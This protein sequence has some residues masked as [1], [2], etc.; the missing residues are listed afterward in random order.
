[1]PIRLRP[2]LFCL[3]ILVSVRH[4]WAQQS[5]QI[6]LPDVQITA[7]K[8]VR[9][10]ADTY[11]LGDWRCTFRVSLDGTF[12]QIDGDI[13]FSE[14]AN[15]FTTITGTFSRRIEVGELAKCRLC[16]VSLAET[17]GVAAGPNIG[18]RG[19]R[20]YKGEG[21][22]RRARIVTD[23]FGEDVGHIGGT[24][25]FAPVRVVVRCDYAWRDE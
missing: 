13:I 21:I 14:K 5:F 23:T 7:D 8:L 2:F 24:V 15:D 20:W 12:L 1:M 6:D 18:A 16:D 11:G 9:G 22:I 17:G 3:L 19:Y 10:D 25:Q 4:T